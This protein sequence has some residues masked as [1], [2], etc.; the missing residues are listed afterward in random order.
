MEINFNTFS[1]GINPT[2]DASKPIQNAYPMLVNGRIYKDS[3][4]A[5]KKPKKIVTP[6]GKKQGIYSLDHFLILFIDG[7]A[8]YTDA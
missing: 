5:I 1:G 8:W 6:V 2:F 4:Q 3:V 7:R